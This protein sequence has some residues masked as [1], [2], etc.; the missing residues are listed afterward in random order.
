[1]VL[2]KDIFK[3]IVLILYPI[4]ILGLAD[5]EKIYQKNCASCH[6]GG[7]AKAPHRMFLEM[8]PTDAI[9]SSLT[10]GIMISQA[11][12]LSAE[13]KEKLAEHLSKVSLTSLQQVTS[14]RCMGI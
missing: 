7:V 9:Y 2:L 6:E 5:P 13:S 10:E 8:M 14:K 3:V 12:N 4:F 1:M 11:K